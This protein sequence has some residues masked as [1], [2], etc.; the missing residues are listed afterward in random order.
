MSTNQGS[1]PTQKAA[2]GSAPYAGVSP[3]W[4]PPAPTDIGG[5]LDDIADAVLAP[6][7]ANLV[8][9]GP[10]SGP[11]ATPSF[12]ALV[13]ADIPNLDASQ[14]TTG[15]LAKVRGGLGTSTAAMSWPVVLYQR[16]IMY[17]F[18]SSIWYPQAVAYSPTNYLDSDPANAL[19]YP[20]PPGQRYV[21]MLEVQISDALGLNMDFDVQMY[22]VVYTSGLIKLSTI[23]ALDGSGPAKISFTNGDTDT[24]RSVT[25]LAATT[26]GTPITHVVPAV[27]SSA[28]STYP[29]EIS[30]FVNSAP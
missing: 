13:A 4:P 23:A 26:S 30:I 7:A 25:F 6:R 3:P 16:G 12:R 24:K 11:S 29:G 19:R 28:V 17:P 27:V 22:G 8:Y 15:A 2:G 9:A 21:G 14:I 1:F 10:A 18:G 20:W 5:A